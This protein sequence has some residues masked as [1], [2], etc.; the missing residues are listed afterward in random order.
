M[1]AATNTSSPNCDGP[2]A[3]GMK[4]FL[5]LIVSS[6]QTVP[7]TSYCGMSSLYGMYGIYMRGVGKTEW[8]S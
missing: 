6:P 7:Q 3:G 2:V 1:V 5:T 8:I 4:L